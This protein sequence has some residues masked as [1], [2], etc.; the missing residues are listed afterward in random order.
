MSDPKPRPPRLTSGAI[1]GVV[2]IVAL[3][4]VLLALIFTGNADKIIP[5]IV[6]T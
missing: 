2:A 3:A 1:V 6:G 4:V 5:L